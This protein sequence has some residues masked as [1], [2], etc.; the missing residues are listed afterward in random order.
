MQKAS[1]VI[2]GAGIAGISAAYSLA[3]EK[4]LPE[5]I[6][7]DER[8]PLSL[9]S[10]RSTEC[11]RNSWPSAPMIALMNRSIDRLESLAQA[12]GNIFHLNRRGYLYCT[13]DPG[14]VPGLKQDALQVSRLGGGPLRIH[15]GQSAKPAYLP[16]IAEGYQ[17]QPEGA[18]L[19]LDPA[20]IRQHFPYLNPDTVAALH[21][22]RAGWFSAQQLG[23]WMLDQ[24]RQHGARLL[25]GKVTGITQPGGR[26]EAV[27]L[28]DGTTIQTPIF[29]NAAGPLVALVARMTGAELPVV[30]ELHLK[31]ALKDPLG[32]LDRSAPLIIWL[33]PQSLDWSEEERQGLAEDGFDH[34]L[35]I[36][37]A[38]IHTRPEGGSGSPIILGL[39]E[40][41]LEHCQPTWPVPVDPLY[42]EVVLRGLER[43]LPGLRAYRGRAGRPFVDGGYY[44]KTP[45]NRPL[46]GRLPLEGAYVIG[47]LS[48]YGLMAASAAGELLA[49]IISG[50]PVPGYAPAFD[51]GRF[52]DPAYL[53]ELESDSASG[54]L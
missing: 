49:D 36:L 41:H 54:Q 29:I 13:A 40:Y 7:V 45:E 18:D 48:G 17:A 42:P 34:L 25:A 22:R 39:W 9:T 53:P 44:T 5:V 19:L 11:Y 16:A 35:G 8:P 1:A 33:D 51:P 28:E 46:I 10:D 43:I 38:G 15:E 32:V 21:V 37:P 14:R 23:M 30:H 4:G 3:V 52:Q 26:V 12:S 6:L 24:A 31:A 47:A 27:K 20:L 2:C 50:G